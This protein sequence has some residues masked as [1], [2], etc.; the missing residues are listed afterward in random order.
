M[1]DMAN[2]TD[3]WPTEIEVTSLIPPAT[4]LRQQESALGKKTRNI[5][6]GEVK[7]R[8][9][10]NFDFSYIFYIV[11]P[12]LGN[13]RY[14]LL[15]IYHNIELYP[16]IIQVEEGIYEEISSEEYKDKTSFAFLLEPQEYK[17][18]YSFQ[19]DSEDSF[20]NVLKAIFNSSKAK[21]VISGLLAQSNVD[22]KSSS[23]LDEKTL[24]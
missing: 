23:Q 17:M 11:A 7:A 21:R 8:E 5:V 1:I 10:D 22:Y 19:A 12:A 24:K 14:K 3:L 6:L 13:Y 4:I 15:T 20:L 16:A 2:M 9:S 18:P